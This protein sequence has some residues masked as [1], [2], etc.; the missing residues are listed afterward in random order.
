VSQTMVTT[1][2]TKEYTNPHLI[3]REMAQDGESRTMLVNPAKDYQ[4]TTRIGMQ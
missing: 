4:L 1:R 2:P 3:L